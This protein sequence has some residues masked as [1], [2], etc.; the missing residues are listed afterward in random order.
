MTYIDTEP[1][2]TEPP[3]THHRWLAAAAAA[4]TVVVIAGGL[5]LASRDDDETGCGPNP[6]PVDTGVESEPAPATEVPATTPPPRPADELAAAEGPFETRQGFIGLPPEGATP[7]PRVDRRDA[8]SWRYAPIGDLQRDRPVV[9]ARGA[10]G[11]R[12]WTA[13]L[14]EVRGSSRGCELAVDGSRP[15]SV[16]HPRASS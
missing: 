8:E 6:G 15:S 12:R 14:A 11:P 2:P 16:S 7:A 1:T 13:D 4:A 9:A 5:V 3:T 10:L